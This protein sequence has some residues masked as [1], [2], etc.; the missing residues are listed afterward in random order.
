MSQHAG[1]YR[2]RKLVLCRS[3]IIEVRALRWRRGLSQSRLTRRR[4]DDQLLDVA[5]AFA[6]HQ[7]RRR[8][9]ELLDR[10]LL[11][12]PVAAEDPH[13]VGRALDADRPTTRWKRPRECH[14]QTAA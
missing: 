1:G 9:V 14:I 3:Y 5:R 10:V 7:Q 13:R 8:T 12:R 11:A 6:D 4:R 2:I